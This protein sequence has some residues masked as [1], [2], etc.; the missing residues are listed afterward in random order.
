MP[1]WVV[2]G[3]APATSSS[4]Q[5]ESNQCQLSVVATFASLVVPL[6]KQLS[7]ESQRGLWA[8]FIYLETGKQKKKGVHSG[9]GRAHAHLENVCNSGLCP[10]DQSR[11]RLDVSIF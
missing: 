6:P 2:S 11:I 1:S 4:A 3:E 7:T 5:R 8:L 10:Q 9:T